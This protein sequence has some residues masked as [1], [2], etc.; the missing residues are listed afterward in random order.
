MPVLRPLQGVALFERVEE[1]NNNVCG[2]H[3]IPGLNNSISTDQL[4]E[5]TYMRL[6]HEP[7]KATCLVV[8][9]LDDELGIQLRRLSHME[10]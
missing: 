4:I 5:S 10:T 7:G 2:L 6:G 9:C 1:L 8:K 3:I